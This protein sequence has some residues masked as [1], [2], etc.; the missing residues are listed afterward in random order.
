MADCRVLAA[1]GIN[2]R[3]AGI[4]HEG[5]LSGEAVRGALHRV[6]LRLTRISLR[7]LVLSSLGELERPFAASAPLSLRFFGHSSQF[8]DHCSTLLSETTDVTHHL[9]CGHVP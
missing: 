8:D 9:R 3:S 2:V 7:S 4:V 6:P 5:G 1:H